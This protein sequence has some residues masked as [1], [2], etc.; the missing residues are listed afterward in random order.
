V[1]MSDFSTK[2]ESGV[3]MSVVTL[4]AL[5]SLLACAQG[6]TRW[7]DPSKHQVRFV[8]VEDGVRLEVLDW[9]GPGRSIVLLAGLGNTA[10]VFDGFAEKLG[11]AYHVYGITRRGFGASSHPDFG[12]DQQRLADDV[13]YV[14]DS[15][16]LT[17]P[18]LAG[19]SIAGDELTTIG[20]QHSDRIG[21]LVYLDAAAD[22]TQDYTEYNALRRNLPEWVRERDSPQQPSLDDRKSFQAYHDWQGRTTG[23]AFPES[24][25]RNVFESGSGGSVGELKTDA[26]YTARAIRA[27][28]QKRDYS[29]IR[30][31][32]LMFTNFPLSVEDQIKEHPPKDAQ[33]RA[34]I[35]AV[36]EADVNIINSR[37]ESVRSA[38][39]GVRVVKLPGAH[40]YVFI[41]N[42]TDVLRELRAFLRALL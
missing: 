40:H 39:A 35:E 13:V 24:E 33:E 32:I 34:A 8:T 27:G 22:P 20:A 41:S 30:V 21:G 14:L 18:V 4:L 1:S 10:H 16:K 15:L 17:R 29:R 2:I 3:G 19:H 12:H 11:G 5:A 42:E 31:P 23:A 28:A 6:P 36:Y 37:I 38:H 26:G 9:G 7:R 25:L